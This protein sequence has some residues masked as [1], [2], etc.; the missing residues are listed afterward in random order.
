MEIKFQ[1]KKIGSLACCV[2]RHM[3]QEQTQEVR[4]PDSMPDIGKVLTAWGKPVIRT[5]EWQNSNMTVCGGVMCWVVYMPEDGTDIRTLETWIP[6]QMKWDFDENQ[7]DGYIFAVPALKNVDARSTSARKMMVRVNVSVWGRAMINTETESYCADDLPDDVQVLQADYPMELCKEAGEVLVHMDEEIPFADIQPFPEK[8]LRQDM[9]LTVNEQ[10]VMGSRLVFR[11]EGRLHISY[12]NDGK[13]Y[14]VDFDLPFSQY[15]DLNGDYSQAATAQIVP[16]VT[17]LELERKEESLSVKCEMAAQYIIFD[18]EMLCLAEDAYSI[19]RNVTLHNAKLHLCSI[20]DRRVVQTMVEQDISM[21]AERIADVCCTCDLPRY[22]QNGQITLPCQMQIL[23]YDLQGSLQSVNH[24][25]EHV[26]QIPGDGDVTL[27]AV[28]R[29]MEHPRLTLHGQ[30][31]NVAMKLEL[32]TSAYA[33]TGQWMVTGLDLGE[34]QKNERGRPSLILQRFHDSRLWD[35]AKNC[36]STV[37]AI[38]HTNGFEGEPEFGC[39]L[40]IPVS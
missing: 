37:A 36:G 20:L 27:D 3:T 6:F 11:G 13:V 35:T 21:E 5:K 28:I 4:L 9:H 33:E 17:N 26:L 2:D 38:R 19:E 8:I 39:M 32:D 12:L 31:V 29:S 18:R 7:H 16:V 23:Y 14:G 1:S 24:R 25:M 40:L 10:R 30:Q 34:P 15:A 22:Q